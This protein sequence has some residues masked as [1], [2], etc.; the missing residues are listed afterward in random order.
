MRQ[1]SLHFFFT[2]AER[3]LFEEIPP[4]QPRLRIAF[5]VSISEEIN[6]REGAPR[7]TYPPD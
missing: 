5:A 4:I 1:Y 3:Q 2:L 6:A 7:V